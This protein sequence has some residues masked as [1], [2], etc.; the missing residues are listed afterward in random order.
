MDA[1]MNDTIQIDSEKFAYHF[2]D[3]IKKDNVTKGNML[4]NAKD[5]LFAYLTAYTLAEQFNQTEN[6]DF[7]DTQS[8]D[9]I[10]NLPMSKFLKIISEKSEF[11]P[12]KK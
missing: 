9:E 4:A 10:A 8:P 3:S 5:Q 12:S 1:K 2:M 7:L 11:Y 6:R